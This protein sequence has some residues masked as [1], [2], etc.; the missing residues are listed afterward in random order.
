VLPDPFRGEAV[1]A[2]QP[3]APTRFAKMIGQLARGTL[4]IG[5]DH[6]RALT[7][8]M[9]VAGDS[10]PPLR[11]LILGDLL[12]SPHST[13]ADVTKSLQR[14]R[15]TVDRTL[16]ELHLLG[17]VLIEDVEGERSWRYSL[18]PGVDRDAPLRLVTRNVTTPGVGVKEDQ[19]DL[20]TDFPGDTCAV[21]VRR[22]TWQPPPLPPPRSSNP[23]REARTDG[24]RRLHPRRWSPRL[25]TV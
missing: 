14:P 15:T 8:A 24:L 12:T 17:L 23:C 20:P 19:A 9:R 11:L 3:E 22:R 25:V 5:A 6:A 2:H 7:V 10:V 1:E 4:A 13:T 18:A 21:R 16:Q